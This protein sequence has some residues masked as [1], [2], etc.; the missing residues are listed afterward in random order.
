MVR[1]H[2][3]YSDLRLKSKLS[4]MGLNLTQTVYI[5]SMKQFCQQH[6]LDLTKNS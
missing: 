2:Y 4:L 5:S 3:C 6:D 1:I